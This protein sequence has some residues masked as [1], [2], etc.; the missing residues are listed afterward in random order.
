[1]KALS[2][3]TRSRRL[4]RRS[5]ANAPAFKSK[6]VDFQKRALRPL[7]APGTNETFCL[8]VADSGPR[9]MLSHRKKVPSSQTARRIGSTYRQR[10]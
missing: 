5:E 8:R 10:V 1:M 6:C 4:P 2:A 3:L 9:W 7:I